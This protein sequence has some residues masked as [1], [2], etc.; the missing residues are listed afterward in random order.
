M[1]SGTAT[2]QP[3]WMLSLLFWFKF[4]EN[5]CIEDNVENTSKLLSL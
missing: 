2:Y 4:I 5:K 1:D 3:L